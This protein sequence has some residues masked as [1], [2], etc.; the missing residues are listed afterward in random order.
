MGEAGA[1]S[2]PLELGA[3]GGYA[4]ESGFQLILP[5]ESMVKVLVE[6]A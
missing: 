6:S 2:E 3:A 5:T 1:G 4:S